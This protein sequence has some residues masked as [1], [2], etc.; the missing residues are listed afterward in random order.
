MTSQ[1]GIST[2]GYLLSEVV[3]N[4]IWNVGLPRPQDSSDIVVSTLTDSSN[5][6]HVVST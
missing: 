1:M 2:E 4:L 3:P 6:L 5:D